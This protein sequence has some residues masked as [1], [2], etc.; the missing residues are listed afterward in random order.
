MKKK[1][2][3]CL[4]ILFVVLNI[5]VR[6]ALKDGGS[7]VYKSALWEYTKVHSM[8]ALDGYNEGVIFS[9]L[10]IKNTLFFVAIAS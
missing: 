3:I 1:I 6:Y 9:V 7:I 4:L 10:G 8:N 5:P 2:I